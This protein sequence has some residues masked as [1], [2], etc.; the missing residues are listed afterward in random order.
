MRR[1]PREIPKGE[2]D[3]GSKWPGEGAGSGY[4]HPWVQGGCWC[5]GPQCL[6]VTGDSGCSGC[7]TYGCPAH[8][9]PR[10]LM[11]RQGR[12]Q[13]PEPECSI[14]GCRAPQKARLRIHGGNPFLELGRPVPMAPKPWCASS[15][16]TATA[17]PYPH[18]GPPWSLS[19][20][21]GGATHPP[22]TQSQN[23]GRAAKNNPARHKA[24]SV[25]PAEGIGAREKA[26]K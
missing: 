24:I 13:T 17:G 16:C 21:P 10:D 6:L 26:P 11:E 19:P 9:C 22:L 15:Q 23:I 14:W 1:G 8:P 20:V 4:P 7:R 5:Q 12:G 18:T 3:G 25:P 2:A